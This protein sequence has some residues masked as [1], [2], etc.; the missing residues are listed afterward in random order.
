MAAAWR[1]GLRA[2]WGGCVGRAILP[3]LGG[4]INISCPPPRGAWAGYLGLGG[5]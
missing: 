5:W 4:G 1:W 2:G 3:L